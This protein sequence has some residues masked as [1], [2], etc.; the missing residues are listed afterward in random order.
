MTVSASVR[1]LSAVI[2]NFC[3][4]AAHWRIEPPT[5]P[6]AMKTFAHHLSSLVALEIALSPSC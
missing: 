3:E 2:G 6:T 5:C 1:I 4:L